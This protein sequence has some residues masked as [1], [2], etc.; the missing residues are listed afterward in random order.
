MDPLSQALAGPALY[1]LMIDFF[2]YWAILA[3]IEY[4]HLNN[5]MKRCRRSNDMH[6]RKISVDAK[7]DEDVAAEDTRVKNTDPASSDLSVR[8]CDFRKTYDNL[9]AVD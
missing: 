2:V 9:V 8:L 3:F 7:I 6:L 5:L 4:G 1:F